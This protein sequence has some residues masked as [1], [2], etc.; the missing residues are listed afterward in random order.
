MLVTKN[1]PMPGTLKTCSTKN[2]PVPTAAKIGPISVT[3][4]ISA[5]FRTCLR[6]TLRSASPLARA[7]RT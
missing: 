2:E 3:T 4:G 6:M 5:F 1:L 7:V